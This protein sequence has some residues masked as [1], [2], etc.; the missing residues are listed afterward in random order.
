MSLTNNHLY[1]F[2]EFL[3]DT[4]EKILMRG[5]EQ[6][7]LTPKAFELLTLFVENHG[8]LLKK[9]EIMERIW[10]ESFVE[11]S[12][13]TFNIGQLRK[14]LG[15]DA[16]QPKFIKTIRQH[17]YRFIA[18][19][20]AVKK[21]KLFI[22]E[23]EV[24]PGEIG[25]DNSFEI[26]E[27]T[28]DPI[29]KNTS[30]RTFVAI[31][32]FVFL[33]LGSVGVLFFSGKLTDPSKNTPIL[34]TAFKSERLT[35]TGGVFHA[36]IS[37]D[38]KRMVYSS[39]NGGKEG[40]WIRQLETS[41]NIQ[42]L[43][44]SINVYSGLSFS[45]DGEAIYFAS[46]GGESGQAIYKVLA[47]GGIPKEIV[48][49]T[50]GWFSLSP[51]DKQISFVR[52]QYLETDYCSL[53]LADSDGKNER[54]VLTRPR[55]FRIS[56]N[57]FSPDGRSIAIAIGQSRNGSQEF[58]LVEVDVATGNERE[59]TN[60]KFFNI[61]YLSWLADQSGLL[62]SAS[63]RFF[64]PDRIYQV[65]NRTG[66]AQVLTKDSNNYNHLSL[67]KNFTK[68]VATEFMA[69]FRL[70]IAPIEDIDSARP[71]SYANSRFNF[72]P[73]GR[74]VYSS[75]TDGNFNIWTINSDGTN[76]RQLTSNQGA[77][78]APRFSADER[79]IIFTS[80]RSGTNHVWRMNVDGTNQI[81]LSQGEGGSPFYA[82]SDGNTVYYET[83][84]N[85]NL[86]KITVNENGSSVSNIVSN[87]R[88]LSPE[89]N[90]SADAVAYFYH[91]QNGNFEIRLISLADGK[92]FKTFDIGQ[93]GDYKL[94][95]AKDGKSIFYLNRN[96]SKRIIWR[97]FLDTGKT[98]KFTEFN[99]DEEIEDFDF[100]PDG[101]SF[102]F[103]KGK[104]RH[105][106]FLIEGLK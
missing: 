73:S 15:D 76:Q 60:Q 30:K 75:V 24:A 101:K 93:L 32:I 72:S 61:Q 94:I 90:P 11:E 104:W 42:I 77:N 43:P 81:Q 39:E 96:D 38:G 19:V 63:D 71:V 18:D 55:P 17:G 66:E 86:G 89:M 67:D 47:I 4:K 59:I 53:Y 27:R 56:D 48:S 82:S 98:E 46:I 8:R 34:N 68:M 25:E 36:A 26:E 37:P 35:H 83:A 69:D 78:G 12:N 40:L 87:E 95:W 64:H 7:E 23:L 92:V 54:K 79:Y 3:I 84:L 44:N 50:Q 74:L 49:K 45:H 85:A 28:S 6:L 105:D 10:A 13:L 41:E 62:M 70:W 1:E 91:K 65:S 9:E 80:N 2:E 57:Q 21:E 100:S 20:K 88:L 106:A 31:G 97:L 16:Q 14:I 51:D 102:A 5:D 22:E 99:A 103:I 29:P 58:S 33:I 52:C